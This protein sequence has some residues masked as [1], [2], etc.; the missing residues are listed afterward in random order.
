MNLWLESSRQV[1]GMQSRIR[2][3]ERIHIS[4]IF[5]FTLGIMKKTVRMGLVRK[6]DGIQI[7]FPPLK[8]NFF[9]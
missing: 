3:K 9:L 5:Y 1:D 7:R 6:G 4:I 2:D 8:E